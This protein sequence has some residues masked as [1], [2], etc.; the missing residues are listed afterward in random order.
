LKASIL[1]IGTELTTGQ[2]TNRNAAWIS[3]QL[4]DLG[5]ETVLH[6]TVADDRA[7]IRWALERCRELSSLIFVT[8]GLGPTTDDFTREVIAE[9]LGKPLQFH[10]PSWTRIQARLT[11]FGIRVAESNRQQCYY[12]EG[13]RVIA[14]AEGTADAFMCGAPGAGADENARRVS[15]RDGV[16]FVLPGPPREVEAVWRSEIE[17]LVRARVPGLK[18]RKLLTWQCIGKSEAELGEITEAALAG[19]GLLIGYRAH[20]P[21]V[22][23]KV[24][25][26]GDASVEDMR[27]Y[28]AAIARLDRELAPWI[29]TRQGADLAARLLAQLRRAD[30]V[31]IADS[32]SG[33]ILAERLGALL[34]EPALAAQADSV[35]VTTE[36]TSPRS[37]REWVEHFL[38]EAAAEGADDM[39]QL[40]IAGFTDAG[41]WAFG[42]AGEN[43]LR[44]IEA[45]TTPYRARE[46][47]DRAR[48]HAVEVALKRWSEWL[49]GAQ[50]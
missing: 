31:E 34:R 30:A 40:A 47:A 2:I 37:P 50:H 44:H 12:P 3:S 1:A 33:G 28:D 25:V 6:E 45:L 17:A 27:S 32:L 13:A 38:D 48:R 19:S 35:I 24:W 39:L 43:G 23:V 5:V 7:M 14:N 8:G 26:P 20:R 21:Y 22:E 11:R 4:A 16:T 10:E 36:W 18:P 46:L 15:K 49:E 9:W 42:L 41:E 29:A